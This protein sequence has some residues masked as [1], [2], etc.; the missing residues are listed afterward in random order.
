MVG[1]TNFSLTFKYLFS[2]SALNFLNLIN[3]NL[4]VELIFL[5]CLINVMNLCCFYNFRLVNNLNASFLTKWD[6]QIQ[7]L[8]NLVKNFSFNRVWESYI[9]SEISVNQKCVF[10]IFVST[11]HIHIIQKV[12]K[13]YLY[14]YIYM[15][16]LW[17]IP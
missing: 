10:N 8:C 9:S 15:Y 17:K 11:L 16:V 1:R 12:L 13:F 2:L 7:L 6:L 5:F 14:I 3:F 4:M